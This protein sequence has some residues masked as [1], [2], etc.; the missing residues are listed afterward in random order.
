MNL[1][2]IYQPIQKDLELVE[3]KLFNSFP[4]ENNDPFLK[5]INQHLF[6]KKSQGKRIRP[7]LVF[8]S[9]GLNNH[10]PEKTNPQLITL[11]AALELIHTASLLHDDIIDSTCLRRGQTTLHCKWGTRVALLAGDILYAQAF[12]YL[13]SLQ[14]MRIVRIISETVR[15]L[16]MGE[17][18]ELE[19]TKEKEL[20]QEEY[21]KI[22]ESKTAVLISACCE[23]AGVLTGNGQSGS[24][25]DYG[26]NFG[27]AY[28]IT[29]DYLDFFGEKKKLGKPVYNDLKE[30]NFT[31]PLIYLREKFK[32][33]LPP[34]ARELKKLI[35]ENGILERVK[36]KAQNYSTKA[37]EKLSLFLPSSYR[38]S[39]FQ[40][41]DYVHLRKE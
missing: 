8:F 17:I 29:D 19:K 6:G 7:A 25:K 23:T 4:Q 30:N 14:D 33:N 27:M 22:I 41:S 39:L 9:A 18:I 38:D 34:R 36:A 16:C 13:S 28:Q 5:K 2:E 26:L 10:N 37:K 15:R 31:L 20:S 1:E 32:N 24:L 3:K 12:R 40:L 35:R 21:L 11:S